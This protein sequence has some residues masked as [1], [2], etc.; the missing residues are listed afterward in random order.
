MKPIRPIWGRTKQSDE[1][2]G[3]VFPVSQTEVKGA[4]P[5]FLN[6]VKSIG[7]HHYEI[8]YLIH[9]KHAGE[10]AIV[11]EKIQG[12]HF[13]ELEQ[14]FAAQSI[15]LGINDV[16]V[17]GGMESMSNVP[18]KGSGL[19][20]DS[21][22]DGMLKDGLWDVYKDVGMGVCVELCADN[23]AIPR[24]VVDEDEGLGKGV[25]TCNEYSEL[26]Q[27]SLVF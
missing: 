27:L 9:E 14:I 11:N 21:L 17:A 26:L 15:Q 18:K 19:G 12:I 4:E 2:V 7:M 8:A 5:D 25:A 3:W 24:D 1:H 22:V 6:G 13:E 23:H 20:H 16:V 10:V